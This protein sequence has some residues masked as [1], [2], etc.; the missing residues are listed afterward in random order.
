MRDLKSFNMSKSQISSARKSISVTLDEIS[1][2]FEQFY[3]IEENVRAML[4]GDNKLLDGVPL[5]RETSI[6][7]EHYLENVHRARSE[8][9]KKLGKVPSHTT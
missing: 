5:T 4:N 7:G 1:N 6:G 2:C 9:Y 3:E 8:A